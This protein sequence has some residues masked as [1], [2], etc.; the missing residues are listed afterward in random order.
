LHAAE[1]AAAAG[2]LTTSAR[3]RPPAPAGIR[4]TSRSL[5]CPGSS[6]TV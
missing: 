5:G 1:T 6:S 2:M 4:S 3:K